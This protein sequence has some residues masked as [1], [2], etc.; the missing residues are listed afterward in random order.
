M[1]IPGPAGMLRPV[2][3]DFLG[4]GR[5]KVLV[6]CWLGWLFDF[7]DLVLFAFTKSRIASDLGL[8]LRQT[9]P[10]VEGWT[11]LATAIGGFLFG[12][13]ADRHGRR[14]ALQ[15]S[16]AVYSIGAL[17]TSFA[18][19]LNS[20]VLARIVTG[21]GVG[22]EWGIGHAVIA[23][24]YPPHL[25]GRAAGI[26]QAATPIAM[27]LAAGVGCLVA[28][29]VGWRAC[30]LAS[31]LPAVLVVFARWAVPGKVGAAGGGHVPIRALFGRTY[32]RRSLA[33]LGLLVVHMAGF[34]STYSWM[35]TAL[36]QEL[37]VTQ[38]QVFWYQLTVNL[39][40][41]GADVAFGFLADRFG[42]RWVFA[43]LCLFFT[44]GISG[45]ALFW[46]RISGD[47]QVFTIAMA[48]AGFGT[49]TWSCFGPLFTAAY[50]EQLRATAASGFYNLGRGAQFVMQPLLGWL[51]VLYQSYVPALWVGAGMGLASA[52]LIFTV[53]ERYDAVEPDDPQSVRK[54][55]ASV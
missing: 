27:A 21:L 38:E 2:L 32:W 13:I 17:A 24:T 45:I 6:F 28:P 7:Y 30:F 51:F 26:L 31:A 46:G 5:G 11:F 40:Q 25:R 15:L 44:L 29:H 33:L 23:E 20:L 55:P 16:I 49:G 18:E 14:S 4:H 10:W 34:W 47:L 36:I 1:R 8:D 54:R 52:L 53:R 19:G 48:I 3:R 22:G 43:L 39:G 42:R 35:P 41:F 12:R 9:I 37:K 50:P